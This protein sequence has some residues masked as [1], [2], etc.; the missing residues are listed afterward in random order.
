MPTLI[1]Y[2]K[3]AWAGRFV[4]HKIFVDHQ[5]VGTI[6]DSEEFKVD[7]SPGEHLLQLKLFGGG[8]EA[9]HF[10]ASDGPIKFTC[11]SSMTTLQLLFPIY[12]LIF[13]PDE[14]ITL[15]CENRASVRT[16]NTNSNHHNGGGGGKMIIR[17][18]HPTTDLIKECPVGFS[19]TT[20]FFGAFVPLLRSMY[21]YTVIYLLAAGI[22][23]GVAWIVFPFIINKHYAK[24]LLEKGYKPESND[25]LVMLKHSGI[26]FSSNTDSN[27]QKAA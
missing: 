13:R 6:K 16:D 25:D 17:M 9:I 1:I 20:V 23:S 14:W 19:W 5:H 26:Q 24:F 7:I 2:R 15:E 18:R 8:S 12:Y 22:T 21:G 3:R 10:E 27:I 11:Q 4:G